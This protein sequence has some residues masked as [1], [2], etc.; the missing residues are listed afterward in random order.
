MQKYTPTKPVAS[1]TMTK[2]ATENP[3]VDPSRF[4][5]VLRASVWWTEASKEK[6]IKAEIFDINR[7]A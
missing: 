7:K 4:F 6:L 2:A 5:R 3:G 1:H